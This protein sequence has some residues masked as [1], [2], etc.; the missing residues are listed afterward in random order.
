MVEFL[1]VGLDGAGYHLL[2][3]WI[4]DG[5]LPT[6]ASYR[7]EGA[8]GTLRSAY[9]PVT[10]PNWRCYSTG[11]NPGKHGVFWWENVDR[12]AGTF[13]IPDATDFDSPDLWDYLGDAGRSSAV[14][15]MPTTFPPRELAG[16]MVSGGGGVDGNDYTYPPE[17]QEEIES[18][19][20]YRAFL[21]VTTSNIGD[22]PD[23]VDDIIELIEMRFDVADY[24]RR[25][26]D[27][28]FLHLTVFYTNV[29]NHHFWDADVTRRVWRRVDA[30]LGEFVEDE[31]V[32]V[33]S[34]HGSNQIHD[35]FTINTWLE[36]EGYLVTDRTL[37]DGLG[38]L[39]LTR[40]RLSRLADALGL[41]N[42]L[43]AT[44]PRRLIDLVPTDDGEV[45]GAGKAAKIDWQCSSAMASGQG[46][47]YV[48]E[49]GPE[50][51]RVRDELR[52]KLRSLTTP[53]GRPVARDVH[54]AADIY[55]GP[56]TDDGPD[57]VIDQADNV[58]ISGSIGGEAVFREPDAWVGENH[59]DGIILAAGPDIAGGVDLGLVDIY[60]I[61]PT[62]LHWFGLPVPDQIDGSVIESMFVSGSEAA[63]RPVECRAWDLDVDE[64]ATA[65]HQTQMRNRLQDLGYLSE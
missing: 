3:D 40:G 27:P 6:L 34:D 28:D 13:T 44:L 64:A 42:A 56:Y 7:E 12:E 55:H 19:F 50:R 36:Q 41:K 63:G 5:T 61:M 43:K 35:V 45:T 38:T 59:R 1:V 49:T 24:I 20:D 32:V 30:L 39:G 65:D 46:P 47:V 18:R 14:V 37:S 62:V 60:D 52:G 8:R 21:D 51:E 11:V 53:D 2:G 54:L 9:P 16:Y 22:H 58:H 31:N 57:L 23:K 15:N 4:E 33:M 48:L 26:Y 10:C 29:F 17:L 25:T